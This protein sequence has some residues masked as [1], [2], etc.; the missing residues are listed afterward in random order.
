[1]KIHELKKGIKILINGDI[2]QVFRVRGVGNS[3]YSFIQFLEGDGIY[4]S[5]LGSLLYKNKAVIINNL[6]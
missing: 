2:K 6:K 1:M 4:S 3:A 5:E